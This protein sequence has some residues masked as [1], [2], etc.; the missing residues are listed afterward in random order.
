MAAHHD[1]TARNTTIVL[2]L[3]VLGL[4]ALVA[5][6]YVDYR[7]F[8]ERVYADCMQ[9]QT[10]DRYS[11]DFRQVEVERFRQLG[12]LTSKS[13]AFDAEEKR[14]RND[15]YMALADAAEQAI[16]HAVTNT[17]CELS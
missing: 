2:A 14:I 13:E 8:K 3:L 12:H 11:N 17:P 5:R 15:A 1:T 6:Q 4:A 9:R 16:K 10:Y 7:M